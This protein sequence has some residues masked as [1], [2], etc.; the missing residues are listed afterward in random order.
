M[1]RLAKIKPAFLLRSI[2]HRSLPS[3][4]IFSTPECQALAVDAADDRN[5]AVYGAGWDAGG[6]A[7]KI[8]VWWDFENCNVPYGID[9]HRVGLNIVSGLRSSGFKGPVSISGYGDMLQLSRC[10]QESLSA[11]GI[12]LHHVPSGGKESESSDRALLMDLI[13]WTIENPPPAHLFLISGDRDFS[14]AL[15]K[16]RMRNYNVLLAC[17]AGAYIS[18][19]LL[20]AA[21]RVWYWNSLVRGEALVAATSWSIDGPAPRPILPPLLKTPPPPSPSLGASSQVDSGSKSSQ[22]HKIP[23]FSTPPFSCPPV[24]PP[25]SCSSSSSSSSFGTVPSVLP[26]LPQSET[27]PSI[28]PYSVSS[29]NFPSVSSA[30]LSP[31]VPSPSQ[32]PAAQVLTIKSQPAAVQ[33]STTKS[34]SAAAQAFTTKS[35]ETISF[36]ANSVPG[37]SA[38]PAPDTRRAEKA[39]KTESISDVLGHLDTLLKAHPKGLWLGD[40]QAQM[41]SRKI[42]FDSDFYGHKK[43][44][45]YLLTLPRLARVERQL[46]KDNKTWSYL[47]FPS[48]APASDMK[49]SKRAEYPMEVLSQLNDLFRQYPKGIW[50]AELH[51]QLVARN[52]RLEPNFYGHAKIVPFLLSLPEMVKIER[53]YISDRWSYIFLWNEEGSAKLELSRTVYR[54]HLPVKRGVVISA[55][56]LEGETAKIGEADENKQEAS[57]QGTED[58]VAKVSKNAE[59]AKEGIP[60]Q[61]KADATEKHESV[62]SEPFVEE[63]KKDYALV[64]VE[65][66]TTTLYSWLSASVSGFFRNIC[67]RWLSPRDKAETL[68]I[69][70]GCDDVE[71]IPAQQEQTDL[72]ASPSQEKLGRRSRKRVKRPTRKLASK[73]FGLTRSKVLAKQQE[74]ADFLGTSQEITAETLELSVSGTSQEII[75]ETPELSEQQTIADQGMHVTSVYAYSEERLVED[76]VTILIEQGEEVLSANEDIPSCGTEDYAA[77]DRQEEVFPDNSSRSTEFSTNDTEA[78]TDTQRAVTDEHQERGLTLQQLSVNYEQAPCTIGIDTIEQ[79]DVDSSGREKLAASETTSL[80]VEGNYFTAVNERKPPEQSIDTDKVLK[81]FQCYTGDAGAKAQTPA[82]DLANKVLDLLER[83]I[84]VD[85]GSTYKRRSSRRASDES[86]NVHRMTDINLKESRTIKD[87]V[88]DQLCRLGPV[89]QGQ[90]LEATIELVKAVNIHGSIQNKNKVSEVA[91]AKPKR[92]SKKKTRAVPE[93]NATTLEIPNEIQVQESKDIRGLMEGD[94]LQ[95]SS[96]AECQLNVDSGGHPNTPKRKPRTKAG[97]SLETQMPIPDNKVVGEVTTAKQKDDACKPPKR[98]YKRKGDKAAPYVNSNNENISP[99]VAEPESQEES[100]PVK[101]IKRKARKQKEVEALTA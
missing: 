19:S 3:R 34:Q 13:L 69:E 48:T 33:V 46:M 10:V 62:S 82:D 71:S 45:P 12:R 37:K 93:V 80:P 26:P 41:L 39:S 75:V 6:A 94:F 43:L 86:S 96:A 90:E 25:F 58:A 18:P 47:F 31:S 51:A 92:Q 77:L 49:S 35:A 20:G 91:V 70:K 61:G 22:Q 66:Q 64:A 79:D 15:H 68:C 72:E 83:S 24:P 28:S 40:L 44:V 56:K 11:T 101:L 1:T 21:S 98:S 74:V 95:P 84:K 59:A 88:Q 73:T 89:C 29:P 67:R 55:S 85:Q 53:R 42:Q 4:S 100:P 9:A 5:A 57:L 52:I 30:P 2:Q 36:K 81:L 17:P 32:P 38:N 8:G 14:T 27:A 99:V 54:K 76:E 60:L 87:E 97:K 50:L 65:E 23:Y 63:T 16:L 7:V 78:E